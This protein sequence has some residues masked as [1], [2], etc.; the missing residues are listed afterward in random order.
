[1]FLFL[2]IFFFKYLNIVVIT[3]LT[4]S[5]NSIISVNSRSVSVVF[6]LLIG[7]SFLLLGIFNFFVV[8]AFV[9]F[10]FVL[11]ASH[12]ELYIAKFLDFVI[13][14]KQC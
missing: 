5:Y 3:I 2:I 14:L 7:N 4:S 9:L 8:V 11:D 6:L 12:C 10:C 13:F 1:M